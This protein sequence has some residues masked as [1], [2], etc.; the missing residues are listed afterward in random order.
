ML[1]PSMTKEKPNEH[2]QLLYYTYKCT[3]VKLFTQPRQPENIIFLCIKYSPHR[4]IIEI[5]IMLLNELYILCHVQIDYT[6][7]KV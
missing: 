5:K 1:F 6:M 3:D 7:D 2:Q 4:K